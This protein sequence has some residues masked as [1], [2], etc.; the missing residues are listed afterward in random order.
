MDIKQAVA[1]V[2]ENGSDLERARLQ[3]ILYAVKPKPDVIRPLTG[4]QNDDGGFPHGM[5]QG[6]LST[7][8]RTVAA[9]L[10]MDE[11]G[12]LESSAADKAYA[13]LLAVQ[14]DDGGWD[15]DPAVSQYDLPPWGRP[16]E[17][18]ARCYLSASSA[19]WLAVRGY[20]THPAF[21]KALAF[22]LK[23]RNEAGKFYGFLHTTWIAAGVFHMAGA[24][25][26]EVVRQAL[27]VLMHRPLSEWVDSQ[28]CWA[29]DGLGRA[30]VPKE[31]PFVEKGLAE[32]C[33][34][35]APNGSWSSEDGEARAVGATIEAL[36][37][38]RLYGVLPNG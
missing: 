29:L 35:Q 15:E 11:L 19:Y 1:F 31:Q 13:Y 3:H 20:T 37:V 25:Y 17:L 33:Q 22:L 26:A 27:Q 36:K 7:V 5:V 21:H 23:H 28:I 34:R 32:L 24:Q 16:G 30:G 10:R 38:L 9:L 4:L 14:K 12:M 8:G 2:E 18:R 6:N